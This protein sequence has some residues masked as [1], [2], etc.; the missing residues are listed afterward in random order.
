MDRSSRENFN[1]AY[2]TFRKHSADLLTVIQD[3]E[4]LAWEL[5]SESVVTSTVVEFAYNMTHERGERTSKLLMA[6]GSQISAD[7][8]VFDVFLSAVAKRASMI[9][10]CRR[11]KDSYRKSPGPFAGQRKIKSSLISLYYR[12]CTDTVLSCTRTHTHLSFIRRHQYLLLSSHTQF[13][14]MPCKCSSLQFLDRLCIYLKFHDITTHDKISQPSSALYLHLT[15]A[16]EQGY[17]IMNSNCSYL[18][19]CGMFL[20]SSVCTLLINIIV[21]S[22][23]A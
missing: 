14:L 10:L 4:V 23:A 19:V 3:P 2:E 6:V 17:T 15:K 11:M 18:I 22:T 5:F 13:C 21:V 7:P 12:D 20:T 8:R 9:D 1:P 16:W